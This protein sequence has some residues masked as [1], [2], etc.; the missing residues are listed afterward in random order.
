MQKTILGTRYY[1]TKYQILYEIGRAFTFSDFYTFAASE[2][3]DF[4]GDMTTLTREHLE[5]IVP[6]VSVLGASVTME[7]YSGIVADTAGSG[8]VLQ[9]FNR[10]G[11]FVAEMPE[12]RFKLNPTITDLGTRIS[13]I[14]I[15]AS[16]QGPY[17]TAIIIP[18]SLPF[19]PVTNTKVLIRL[20]NL[21][22]VETPLVGFRL[23]WFEY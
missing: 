12:M 11:D 4:V 16:S 9:G 5:A 6:T 19:K 2:V 23:N 1:P 14:P 17:S 3:K 10:N 8:S 13:A 22:A 21:D 20:T 18:G 15:P 7:V